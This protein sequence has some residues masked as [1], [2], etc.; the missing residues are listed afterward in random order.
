MNNT[1]DEQFLNAVKSMY[2]GRI[3]AFEDALKRYINTYAEE[4]PDKLKTIVPLIKYVKVHTKNKYLKDA[5]KNV[6][7]LLA[8]SYRIPVW[9]PDFLL[10]RVV[11]FDKPCRYRH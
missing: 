9:L 3:L 11:L 10:E 2:E 1:Y 5:V 6:T 7:K 4:Y 8:K